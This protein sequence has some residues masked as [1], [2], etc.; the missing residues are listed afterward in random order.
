MSTERGLERAAGAFGLLGNLVMIT[1]LPLA[2]PWPPIGAGPDDI[3]RY[4]AEHQSGF[5]WQAWVA[6]AGV[7]L[8]VPFAAALAELLQRRGAPVEARV[9]W[10]AMLLF[11]SAFALEWI[12]WIVLALRP[13]GPD[14]TEAVYDIGLVGQFVG[15]GFPLALLFGALA[16]GALR[17]GALP[18]WIA[19]LAGLAVP[20][21]VILAGCTAQSGPFAP[22]GA[23]GFASIGLFGFTLTSA[24]VVLLVRSRS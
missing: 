5:L 4:F 3:A 18:R 19:G 7:A 22:S 20:L 13:A 16:T 24:S 2:P 8:L 11:V 14:V 15:V 10:G 21:N 12:P 17:T 9:F 23:I 1:S 6:A